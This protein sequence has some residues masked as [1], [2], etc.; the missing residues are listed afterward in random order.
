MLAA[1]TVASWQY[2]RV[3]TSGPKADAPLAISPADSTVARLR[4]RVDEEPCD[5]RR[6]IEL[7]EHS[8]REGNSR[9]VLSRSDAFFV[10]CGDYSRLRELRYGAHR[11]LGDWANAAADASKLI[12]SNPHNASY[13]GWRAMIHEQS[14]D[15]TRASEDYEQALLLK[16]SLADVPATLASVYEKL[17]KPCSAILPLAQVV[18]YYPEASDVEVVHARIARLAGL[19][20]CA[21]SAG[22]GHAVIRRRPGDTVMTARVRINGRDCGIFV[23]DTGATF[24]ALSRRAAEAIAL[25]VSGKPKLYAQ[26]AN[27]V[28]L[29]HAVVLDEVAVQ[30]LRAAR[31]RAAVVDNLGE[32]DGLLGMSF[33]SRFD[34]HHAKGVLEIDARHRSSSKTP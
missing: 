29:G 22:Q 24:V 17:G 26:T 15:L 13:H 34:F 31:V 28:A 20:E 1:I 5:R 8:L 14:G 18:T 32:I 6:I 4:A 10:K 25:D 16:P 2:L 3:T 11:Q 30:G 7:V 12:E 19:G 21:W 33:L 27:G 9:E 23:V